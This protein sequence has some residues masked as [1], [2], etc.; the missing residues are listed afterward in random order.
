MIRNKIQTCKA[1]PSQWE[2]V[3]NDGR[4]FYIRYRFGCLSVRVSEGIDGHVSDAVNG[5]E[6]YSKRLCGSYDGV[7]SWDDIPL[8]A[9]E[10]M[11]GER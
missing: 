8:E 11:K 3:L 2:G 10:C 9:F 6:V 4:R 5:K 1:F 7:L